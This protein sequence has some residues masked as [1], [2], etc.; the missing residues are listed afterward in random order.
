VS[1]SDT[2]RTLRSSP[3]P[4][5]RS[6][7]LGFAFV[8]ATIS[9]VS[10]FTNSYA[11][12]RVHGPATFTTAKNLVAAILLGVLLLALSARGSEEGWT[13]PRTARQRFGLLVVGV[14]GGS[15]PFVLFF[16]GLARATASDAAFI[17][18]TL[19]V[20]VALLGLLFLRERM[21]W[22]HVVAIAALVGGQILLTQ[23]LSDV[24]LGAGELMI[25]AATLLWSV[26]VVIAK[27]LLADLSALTVGVSRMVIGAVVLIGWLA[28]SGQVGD[29]F[30]YS[31]SQWGW[32]LLTGVLLTG[33]VATWYSGLARAQAVD[34]TAILVFGAVVTAG[35]DGVFK[36]AAL[37]PDLGGFGLVVAGVVAIA[38]MPARRP[39]RAT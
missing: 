19:V 5:T 9:G 23:H 27:R 20:W 29:L 11:V 24:G 39:A 8:T 34:V 32:V 37:R 3:I 31:A 14:V 17:Q 35:L 25:F 36:G 13:S 33:Y 4:R 7:G 10:I 16:E 38:L 2:T 1:P 6:V 18:K 15:V 28:V 12:R 22:P 30:D 21:G 26:E